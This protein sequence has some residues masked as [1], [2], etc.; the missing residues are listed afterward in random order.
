MLSEIGEIR[1][2]RKRHSLTQSQL[3]KL[4]GVSQSLIAK[5]EAGLLDPSYS[6]FRRISE[7]LEGVGEREGPKAGDVASSRIISAGR[8][9]MLS[10]AV[11]KMKQHGISQLPV[12]E[13]GN[14][15][16]LLAETDVIE[17][18]HSGMDI[19]KLTV[20]DVMG[21]APPTV[22]VKTPLKI[23]TELLRVS[24]LIVVTDKGKPK[25]VV[26]KADVLNR[27]AR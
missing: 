5:T 25:G 11:R 4:S 22:P 24:P 20:A 2:L 26:T 6:N 17:S 15:I 8:N 21:E 7:V 1:I 3:A 16:G 18:I 10:E 19:K 9:E 12:T 14:A 27:L 23:V 13:K